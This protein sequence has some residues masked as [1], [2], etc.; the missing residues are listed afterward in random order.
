MNHG[1][2]LSVVRRTNNREVTRYKA[3]GHTGRRA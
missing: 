3:Y 1:T 2:M